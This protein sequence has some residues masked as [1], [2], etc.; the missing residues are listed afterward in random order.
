[1][2]YYHGIQK[3]YTVQTLNSVSGLA[4]DPA[5]VS[6][7]NAE[8]CDRSRV[9]SCSVGEVQ[10]D[11]DTDL[12]SSMSDFQYRYRFINNKHSYLHVKPKLHILSN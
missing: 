4:T 1:M 10:S 3:F 7:H 5:F 2:H 9:I 8:A 11:T 12:S 6:G